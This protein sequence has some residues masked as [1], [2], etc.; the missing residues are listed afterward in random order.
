MSE[1]ATPTVRFELFS[2]AFCGACHSTRA[3]LAQAASLVPGAIVEEHDV[4]FEPDYCEAHGIETTPTVIVRA[5]D[6][7][8]VFRAEGAPTIHQALTAAALALPH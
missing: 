4:A 3:V 7:R 5:A 6:G 8:A 2:S 1:P